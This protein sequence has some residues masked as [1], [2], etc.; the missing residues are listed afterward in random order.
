MTLHI[1][2]LPKQ[3]AQAEAVTLSYAHTRACTRTHVHTHSHTHPPPNALN[4]H[5]HMYTHTPCPSLNQFY[6]CGNPQTGH[7]AQRDFLFWLSF[8][9]F[10]HFHVLIVN[11][12]PG[13]PCRR[14]HAVEPSM[15]L[16]SDP[17]SWVPGLL[18]LCFADTRVLAA[19]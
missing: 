7:G 13:A 8:L 5:T 17:T 6:D 16:P 4:P 12:T 18:L 3:G 10:P 1:K 9:P 19:S 14:G 2:L 15:P 11:L